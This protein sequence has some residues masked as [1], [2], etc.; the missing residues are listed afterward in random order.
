MKWLID[1]YNQLIVV[2]NYI[3]VLV[4]F[5]MA[6]WIFSD[7]VGRYFFHHP[8][9]GTNELVK[10]YIVAIVFFGV[11]HTLHQGRHIRTNIIV[12]YLP[13]NIQILCNIFASLIGI[14]IFILLSIFALQAAW[15]SWLVREFDGI[16]L[17]IPVY[18][19]RFVVV[20]GSVLM[21]IQC[22]LDLFKHMGSLIKHYKEQGHEF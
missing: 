6:L 1:F 10:C 3:S 12:Q 9:A 8:I 5:L 16:Q 20:L 4:I 21:V 11:T 2:L 15:E 7:V 18:P 19:A 13:S 17:K 22:I 14:M